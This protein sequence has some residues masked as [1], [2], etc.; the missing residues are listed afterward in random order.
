MKKIILAMLFLAQSICAIATSGGLTNNG[1]VPVNVVMYNNYV[2]PT[3]TTSAKGRLN[4]Q[5]IVIPAGQNVNFL[6]GTT[7]IDVFYG[8][9][10]IPGIHATVDVS[11]GYTI[12]PGMVLNNPWVITQD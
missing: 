12:A 5:G 4:T 7:S 2:A 3:A 9:G 10:N 6:P 11:R 8:N 1:S